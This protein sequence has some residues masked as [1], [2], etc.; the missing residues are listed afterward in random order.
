MSSITYNGNIQSYGVENSLGSKNGFR[1]SWSFLNFSLCSQQ[2]WAGT[3]REIEI[4]P[5]PKQNQQRFYIS[6]CLRAK[7]QTYAIEC[8]LFCK[9]IWYNCLVD[10]FCFRFWVTQQ[11]IDTSGY[12][13]ECLFVWSFNWIKRPTN[14]PFKCLLHWETKAT[15]QLIIY[16]ECLVRHWQTGI[17]WRKMVFV[18][19]ME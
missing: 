11:K 13:P 4:E 10:V 18:K 1:F 5:E 14:E 8:D 2:K 7:V 3:K 15:G 12:L 9:N 19:Q 16:C 6:F 17:Q